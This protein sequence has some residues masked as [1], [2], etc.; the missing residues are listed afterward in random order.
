MKHEKRLA[1]GERWDIAAVG[2]YLGYV[3]GAGEI[4]LL[5]D[6]ELHYLGV[7]EVYE[8][9]GGFKNVTIRNMSDLAGDFVIKVG[10]GKLHMSGDGQLVEIMGI[11]Q[12]VKTDVLNTVDIRAITETL[13]TKV[14]NE[15]QANIVNTVKIREITETLTA[16]VVNVVKAEITGLVSTQEKSA[17]SIATT[18]KTFAA[19]EVF[20]IPANAGRRDITIF[21]AQE[22][23]GA[24]T[25]AG[26]PLLAGK[27]VELKNYAGSI[28]ATATATD[29]ITIV[30]V[31]K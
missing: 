4:E 29:T 26:V 1:T 31:I 11:R 18:Q 19:D 17:T 10:M 16:N 3:S 8:S 14:V 28:N 30:E 22:N 24:V 13:T 5:I 27:F 23:T 12:T 2:Q 25:V 20:T 21:A 7:N 9:F 6:G 15:V